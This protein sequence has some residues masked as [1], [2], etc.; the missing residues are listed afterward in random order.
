MDKYKA[1][2]AVGKRGIGYKRREGDQI[3][4]KGNFK[5][6]SLL[7]RK[8]RITNLKSIIGKI[9]IK[10]NMGWCDDP[11]SKKYN[12]L[13]KL[14]FKYSAEKL[15]KKNN[16]YDIVLV[17]DFNLNPVLKGY[18][19]AIFIH[20]SKKKYNSTAGCIGLSKKDLR[21]LIK[22]I[23]KNTIIKIA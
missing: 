18:G 7:Y 11:N 9:T 10:K 4:P 12:K 5:I 16:T 21:N 2:C 1:K 13:I 22:K 3:T 20:V 14:P 8:D 15:Y 17:L 23:D 6:V 19:S